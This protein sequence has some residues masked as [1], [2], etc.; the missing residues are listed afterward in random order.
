MKFA[1]EIP[2]HYL[3]T[4]AEDQ[5]YYFCIAPQVL[6]DKDYKSWYK[7]QSK[8]IVLDNGA[9]ELGYSLEPNQLIDLAYELGVSEVILP[10]FPGDL[11]K[12]LKYVEKFLKLIPPRTPFIFMGVLQGKDYN[13]VK[14]CYDEYSK[15]NLDVIGIPARWDKGSDFENEQFRLFILKNLPIYQ[16][17]HLLGLCDLSF[18]TEY[19]KYAHRIDTSF[20]IVA[21]YLNLPLPTSKP[22]QRLDYTWNFNDD[23]ITLAKKNIQFLK[24]E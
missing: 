24:N 16:E 13:D 10:D 6:E 17:I 23:Q 12:T 8:Y 7:A 5:D 11:L 20:P 3:E 22:K 1:F 18:I 19:K 14:K 15:L 4:F 9:F 21:A 2:T